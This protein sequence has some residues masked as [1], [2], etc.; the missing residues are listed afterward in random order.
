M[1]DFASKYAFA[2]EDSSESDEDAVLQPLQ[3]KKEP[4]PVKTAPLPDTFAPQ[5]L[6]V[7]PQQLFNEEDSMDLI[8]PKN[9][10]VV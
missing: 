6:N 10:I 2:F 9:N 1:A 5:T 7:V 4:S 3:H 8:I